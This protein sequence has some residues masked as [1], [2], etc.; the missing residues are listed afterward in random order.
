MSGQ[1]IYK[2]NHKTWQ[3]KKCTCCGNI[4]YT[5]IQSEVELEKVNL[6]GKCLKKQLTS[7]LGSVK[8]VDVRI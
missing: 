3:K 4:V 1:T 8:H 2:E 7:K 5:S 6:C